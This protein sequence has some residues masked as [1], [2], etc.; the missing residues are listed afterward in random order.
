MFFTWRVLPGPRQPYYKEVSSVPERVSFSKDSMGARRLLLTLVVTSCAI[1]LAHGQPSLEE[2][3]QAVQALRQSAAS[4]TEFT[5]DH[6]MLVL[7]SKLDSSNQDLLRVIAGISGVSVHRYRFAES[8][9]YDLEALR[10][11]KD[12]FNAGGWMQLV[13]KHDTKG[14]PGVTDL[15]IHWQKDAISNVAILIARSNE[16]D[17]FEVSGSISPLDLSHLGGHFGI[18]KIEGGVRVPVQQH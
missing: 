14:V 17:F 18:P 11:V 13:N 8:W 6:P 16:V 15:W 4:K 12:E 5:L 9:G 1:T 7:A 10:S 3:P 2:L